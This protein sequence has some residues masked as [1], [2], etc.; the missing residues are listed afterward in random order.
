MKTA[1]IVVAKIY[2]MLFCLFGAFAIALPLQLLSAAANKISILA[3][4]L[5]VKLREWF[6]DAAARCLEY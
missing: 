5:T 4:K 1:I 3:V 2:L 6:E